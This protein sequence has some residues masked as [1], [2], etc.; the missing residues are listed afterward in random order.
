MTTNHSVFNAEEE[1]DHLRNALAKDFSNYLG[2]GELYKQRDCVKGALEAAHAAGLEEAARIAELHICSETKNGTYCAKYE[3][4][5]CEIAA[6]IRRGRNNGNH[7][8]VG[9]GK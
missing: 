6:A 4:C 9:R 2:G 1:A 8:T 3:E 7:K 5:G